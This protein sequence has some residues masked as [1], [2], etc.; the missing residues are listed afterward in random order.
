MT[1]K[2]D[3]TTVDSPAEMAEYRARLRHERVDLIEEL[4][5]D[6]FEQGQF[7]NLPGKGKP[8]N[9]NKN[10]YAADMELANELLKENDL[11]PVWIL[12]RN[13]ILAK[14]AKLRAEIERQWAWHQR[15]FGV[16]R[17]NKDRLTISWDDYCL[18]WIDEIA[19]LNKGIDAFN[20][21]RP[22]DNMEIFKLTIATELERVQAPRWLR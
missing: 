8:L 4:I 11:P 9:L 14:V 5:Q 15:E 12:Q 2:D 19:E 1:Q 16:A 6:G 3:K 18:K 22:F 10:P 17:S 7:D 13:E 21:K 20:L